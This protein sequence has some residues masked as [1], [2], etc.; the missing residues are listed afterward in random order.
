MILGAAPL[1]ILG[2]VQHLHDMRVTGV[3]NMCDEYAGPESLYRRC[4]ADGYR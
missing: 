1:A 2:H 3:V 4:G